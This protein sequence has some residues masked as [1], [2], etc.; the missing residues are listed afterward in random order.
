MAIDKIQSKVLKDTVNLEAQAKY[1]E[2]GITRIS[3]NDS[4]VKRDSAGNIELQ[5]SKKN[6]L[7]IIE[8]IYKR[9]LNSSVVKV[10]DTQFNYFKFPVRVTGESINLDFDLD[11]SIPEG[12]DGIVN[13]TIPI[14]LDSN[15]QPQN[16]Q[17]ISTTFDST[18]YYGDNAPVSKGY[19]ELPFAGGTQP[20]ANGYTITKEILESLKQ[21]NKTIRFKFAVQYR[22]SANSRTNFNTR[23]TRSNRKTYNPLTLIFNKQQNVT[24]GSEDDSNP[25]GFTVRSNSASD[26]PYLVVTY[27]VDLDDTKAD[28]VY[29][30]SAVAGNAGVILAQNSYWDVDIVDIPDTTNEIYENVYSIND[31]TAILTGDNQLVVLKSSENNQVATLV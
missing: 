12:N 3:N 30:L 6:P 16:T 23:L 20:N 29:K 11:L 8:P 1:K 24:G 22:T 17:K 4:V 28:D 9:I 18:W 7:L 13:L 25:Y 26:Y 27:I 15:Q 2:Q 19:R 5:E 31:D 10:L 21:K 14:P